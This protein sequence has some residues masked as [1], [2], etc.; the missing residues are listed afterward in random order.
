[1]DLDGLRVDHAG[2]DRAAD[3]LRMI[4]T[5]IDARMQPP[6]RTSWP[7]CARSGSATPSGPTRWPKR[8]G[9]APSTRCATCSGSPRSRWPRPTRSTARPTLRGARS[10]GGRS[11]PPGPDGCGSR[12]PRA[13]AEPMSPC[14]AASTSPSWSRSWPATL[15]LSTPRRSTAATGS[16]P[17]TVAPLATEPASSARGRGRRGDRGRAGRRR[18]IHPGARRRRRG[19]GRRHRARHGRWT[20]PAG[21]RVSHGVA[22]LLLLPGAGAPLTGRV[23]GAAIGRWGWRRADR[24]GGRAL[25]RPRR[26]PVGVA[27]LDARTPPWPDSLLP[28]DASPSAPGRRGRCGQPGRGARR[29]LGLR[30]R[31]TLMLPPCSSAP[32]RDARLARASRPTRPRPPRRR[33]RWVVVVASSGVPRVALGRSRTHATCRPRRHRRPLRAA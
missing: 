26:L 1:M 20:L 2:L 13:P 22:L 3:D 27:C 25:P 9:T 21:R 23:R 14:R 33:P 10:F 29:P 6:R 16:R 24:A 11:R 19:D 4:V 15:G 32:F 8:A 17:S 5:R 18:R 12:S 28:G 31:R 30:E 7:R